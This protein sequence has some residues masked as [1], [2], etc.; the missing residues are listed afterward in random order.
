MNRLDLF[1]WLRIDWHDAELEGNSR[2]ARFLRWLARLQQRLG[3][4][5]K[6]L[7]PRR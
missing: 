2:K 4:D 5:R 6:R 7:E 1:L 3:G